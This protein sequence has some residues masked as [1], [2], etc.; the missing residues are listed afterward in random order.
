MKINE[1]MEQYNMKAKSSNNNLQLE[2]EIPVCMTQYSVPFRQKDIEIFQNNNSAKEILKINKNLT[3]KLINFALI[4]E[5]ENKNNYEKTALKNLK[6]ELIRY[7]WQIDNELEIN[8]DYLILK[9]CKKDIIFNYKDL[10]S[11]LNLKKYKEI[12][13]NIKNNSSQIIYI[14]DFNLI[15]SSSNK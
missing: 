14:N 2:T 13:I 7:N 12:H 11:K 8:N 4:K 10:D 5:N 6:N 9:F 1:E 15:Q 3:Q